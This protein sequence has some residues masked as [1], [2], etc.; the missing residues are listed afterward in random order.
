MLI[1]E[2]GEPVEW[3]D[4]HLIVEIDVVGAVVIINS[5]GSAAAA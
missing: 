4:V 3:N 2:R 1:E 5:F